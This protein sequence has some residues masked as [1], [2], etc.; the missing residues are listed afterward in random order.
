[1]TDAAW[2]HELAQAMTSWRMGKDARRETQTPPPP[3]QP[4][5]P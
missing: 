3:D 2:W 4:A 1:M 5:D